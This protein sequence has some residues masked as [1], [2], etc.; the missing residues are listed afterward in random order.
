[1][2]RIPVKLKLC[3]ITV[4]ASLA[5]V[6]SSP[7][8]I[9]PSGGLYVEQ[10]AGVHYLFGGNGTVSGAVFYYVNYLTNDYDIISSINLSANGTFSG[11]ST[12][13]LR[14]ISG[15]IFEN[16]I[17]L[18]YDGVFITGPKIP[19]SGPTRTL[20]GGYLGSLFN[21]S[22]G[23]LSLAT[24]AILPNGR[25]LGLAINSLGVAIG[26][27]TIDASG[28]VSIPLLT[29]EV[30]S[31]HFAPVNGFAQGTISSSFGYT[32]DYS[33]LNGFQPRLANISTRG[34]VG[35]GEQVLI[36]GFI[37]KNGGERVVVRAIGPSLAPLGV[38]NPL[39]N[40]RL[41]LLKSNQIIASNDDWNTG[42][43][44]T[45]IIQLGLAPGDSREAAILVTLEPGAYTVIVSSEDG[46]QGIGLVEIYEP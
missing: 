36:G 45:D 25:C 4:I 39:P 24:L 11:V 8:Q 19:I 6:A 31:T 40:P 41:Q 23:D 43:N 27:G 18:T 7:A 29:G 33:V 14:S 44:A 42:A 46:S 32:Y 12:I 38:A 5:P 20:S 26:V 9:A 28:N 35:T 3:L 15:E 17:S 37:T 21:T 10:P 1:M 30:I 16:S 2:N 34:F 22:T 13:T